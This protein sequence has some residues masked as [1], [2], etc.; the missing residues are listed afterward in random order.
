RAALEACGWGALPGSSASADEAGRPRPPSP[1]PGFQDDIEVL[2]AHTRGTLAQQSRFSS[3][4]LRGV[5]VKV[6]RACVSALVA[7]AAQGSVLVVGEPGAG[8]SGA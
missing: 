6:R 4:Q 3:L 7:A 8:K 1:P 5:E 2:R